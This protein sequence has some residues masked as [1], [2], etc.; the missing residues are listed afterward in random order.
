M[1][2]D[3]RRILARLRG[4]QR[5]ARGPQPNGA[6]GRANP[7]DS[8]AAEI[9]RS[10]AR[11]EARAAAIPA[12]TYPAD[13]PVAA[14]RDEIMQV[15]R[16][17]Q[18][19]VVCGATGSGKTTQL[20]KMLLELGR[21]TRG[22]IGHTQPR[23]IAARSVA[24]RIA[25]ELGTRLGDLVGFKVRFTDQTSPRSLVKLMTDGILLAE[26]QNDRYL[27]QYDTIIIDEAHERSLNI[28]FL[29]GYLRQLLPRRPDLKLIITSA[30]IDPQSFAKHFIQNPRGN[31]GATV[32][33]RPPVA[34]PVIEVTGR[35]F[36]V[37][38]RYHPLEAQHPDEDDLDTE[39]GILR[40]IDEL[41]Q[42][43]DHDPSGGGD[44]LVFL[45]GEREIRETAE[46]L[47][48][49]PLR[50]AH[51]VDVIP[52][53]ARLSA[54]EQQRIFD[55]P[56]GRRRI[57]L[58]TNIAE[59]SL[60]VP[61]IRY[62]IDSGVARI[63]RYSPR[64]KVQ[65]LP[66]EKV[67]RA[68]AD[69]R[70]GRCG[71]TA[72][73]ICIRLYS[74]S[75]FDAR[76][77]FTD[78]EILRTNLASVIL[79]MK[80]LDLGDI[81]SFPFLQAPSPQAIRD[82][83]DTLLEINALE[84][85][86]LRMDL[87]PIG[88][89]LARLPIDPRIG[90]MLLAA[91]SERC[92]SEV[93]VIAA[94]L[95]TQDPRERPIEKQAEADAAHALFREEGSDFLGQLKLWREL[96]KQQKH[97]SGNQFRRWCREHFVSYLRFRE[98]HDVHS[99]L[100]EL[101]S[102][103]G[104]KPE[105]RHAKPENIHRALLTGLL[106]SIGRKNKGGPTDG[107]AESGDYDGARGI[108]FSI[109]PGSIL[110]KKT[111]TWVMAE[112]IVRTTRTYART[113]AS[114]SPAWIEPIAQHLVKRTYADPQWDPARAEAI[115][116]ESQSLYGLEIVARRRVPLAPIDPA[117][118]RALFIQHA[119]VGGEYLTNA[120]FFEHNHT[121]VRHIRRMQEKAR[122]TDLLADQVSRFKFF[123]DRLPPDVAS[124]PHFE[125]WR[126][127]A[128]AGE[129]Q[130]LMMQKQDVL[131]KG[132]IEPPPEQFPD[133]IAMDENGT[134][135]P[136]E[137]KHDVASPDDGI[138]I[139]VPENSAAALTQRR[140]DWLVP[141]VVQD[142]IEALLRELPKS[143][144]GSFVPIPQTAE[145]AALRMPFGNG[146]FLESLTSALREITAVFVAREHWH[147]ERLPK[148]L[149]MN[150]RITDA[151]R[152]GKIIMSGRDLAKIRRE[153]AGQAEQSLVRLPEGAWN[154][155]GIF[156]WDFGP[157]PE[158]IT[159][160]HDARPITIYPA[161]NDESSLEDVSIRPFTSAARAR[162]AHS[163]GLRRLFFLHTRRECRSLIET[164]PGIERLTLL[165][166]TLAS[167]GGPSTSDGEILI[168]SLAELTAHQAWD[169][170]APNPSTDATNIRTKEVFESRL[171]SAWQ[172]IGASGTEVFAL[173]ERILRAHADISPTL[174]RIADRPD[175]APALLDLRVQMAYLFPDPAKFWIRT[176]WEWLRQ[177]PRYLSTIHRRLE[178]LS[179]V[180]GI[181]RDTRL[182]HEIDPWMLK[183]RIRVEQG[184]PSQ[185][186]SPDLVLYRWMV[187]EY[188]ITLW[189]AQ[190]ETVVPV[191]AKRLEQQWER[192]ATG[193]AP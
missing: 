71:R 104:F 144:R 1:A 180:E 137:Y 185:R 178:R 139:I 16:D 147:P 121:L 96:H 158:S 23:R 127:K 99:Q 149:V 129:P 169:T 50:P 21:G 162:E 68:S 131:A 95:A 155:A 42:G 69:Q 190:Q 92:L 167:R 189:G 87:T 133:S 101:M 89:R 125:H 28:D 61:G 75:D 111:P 193:D 47:R 45:P 59:T 179:G 7:L 186:A 54:D 116:H 165:S 24:A 48:K 32:D 30:T 171:N 119:L 3:S 184:T 109:F 181:Q 6:T 182:I 91:D 53:Y 172:R 175:F 67:S 170:A 70:S 134:R 159:I 98:W 55:P 191:S 130:L 143:I 176:P 166:R 161:L 156:D 52:L 63:S 41:S 44:V 8:I 163:L 18:V 142:K 43:A 39:Q 35:T 4:L 86:G 168:E 138:T 14:R 76:P 46:A 78:P 132:A 105:D 80:A 100:R 160:D 107:S 126:R 58:A 72:P 10:E 103:M 64:I 114:I 102:E 94:A 82:G 122:T 12:I 135:F 97:L 113:V 65:R 62:V 77:Q 60:T 20:P 112:E 188:R 29:L 124:G 150:I 66:V 57:I 90:R 33:T 183:L 141:G 164:M 26:T 31:A 27:S 146:D 153:F 108:K 5:H 15:I 140:L 38:S 120:R 56:P 22:W 17:N 37:E 152:P 151:R 173:A 9:T 128:E 85:G 36:P 25:Q 157:M 74:Q 148:H 174:E 51:R 79:Q 84:S 81:E 2:A 177:F 115:V 34:A 192:V 11:V 154:R 19:V 73:G 106:S 118:A 145:A 40:A 13:L 117:A 88:R 93:L 123:D 136:L 49:H 83:Y 110:F 187:E